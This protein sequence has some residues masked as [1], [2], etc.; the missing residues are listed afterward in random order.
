HPQDVRLGLEHLGQNPIFLIRGEASK[1]R[2]ISSDHLQSWELS[3]QCFAQKLRHTG[4]TAIQKIAVAPLD[5]K[6]AHGRHKIRAKDPIH[7]SEALKTANPRHRHSI[8]SIDTC[9]VQDLAKLQ[10]RLCFHHAMHSGSANVAWA[11]HRN[12]FVGQLDCLCQI[13]SRYLYTKHVGVRTLEFAHT[14]P[15]AKKRVW[16]RTAISIKKVRF[17]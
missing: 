5:G 8:W 2:R 14:P 6:A 3:L 13:D 15:I 10:I 17:R 7:L 4:F 1:R 12:P 9:T 11:P 16:I